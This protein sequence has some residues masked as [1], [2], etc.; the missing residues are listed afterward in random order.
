[1]ITVVREECW[2]NA[3]KKVEEMG[4]CLDDKELKGGCRRDA[5]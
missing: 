4:C 1:M 5:Q 2:E 3:E